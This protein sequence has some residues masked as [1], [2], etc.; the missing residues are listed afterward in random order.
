MWIIV[1][2]FQ[3]LKKNKKFLRKSKWSNIWLRFSVPKKIKLTVHF[4]LKSVHVVI[5]SSVHNKPTFSQTILLKNL[6]LNPNNK[7]SPKAEGGF[8]EHYQENTYTDEQ[9][10]QHFE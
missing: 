4:I 10:Q 7:A 3:T 8:V 9:V 1:L 2:K 6:Y 5:C